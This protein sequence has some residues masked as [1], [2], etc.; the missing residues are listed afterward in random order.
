MAACVG[1]YRGDDVLPEAIFDRIF[2]AVHFMFYFL[3]FLFQIQ[4][5]INLLNVGDV[6]ENPRF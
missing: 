1:V 4:A 3:N 5:K 2:F 6:S